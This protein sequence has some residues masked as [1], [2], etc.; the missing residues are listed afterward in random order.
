[1]RITYHLFWTNAYF[2]IASCLAR[3]LLPQMNLPSVMPTEI[4]QLGLY[5]II[6]ATLLEMSVA[7]SYGQI[8]MLYTFWALTFVFTA[9]DLTDATK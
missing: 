9:N 7:I 2:N 6:G 4:T 3:G 5:G 1:M 8:S